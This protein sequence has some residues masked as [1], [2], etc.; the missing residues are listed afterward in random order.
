MAIA[1]LSREFFARPVLRVARALIGKLLVHDSAHGMALGRI[2]ETEAY[3]GPEDL[4]AH[5]ANGRRTR[6]NEPMWGEAGRAYVFQL[7]GMHWAFNVVTGGV[8]EPH[9][10]LVRAVEPLEPTELLARRRGIAPS[11]RELT[12]GPGKL[13]AAFGIDGALSGVDLCDGSRLFIADAPR[14][15]DVGRSSR[16]NVDYAGDWADVP[17]RFFERGN[18][19]VSVKPRE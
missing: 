9:A 10:V 6:R 1:P 17:W 5:T 11:R 7:Y 14:V 13:C 19:Y 12:N 4:A 18:R 15:S 16:I 2:V 3:R 8:G